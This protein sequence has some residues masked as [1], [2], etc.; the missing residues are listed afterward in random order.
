MN[1][2]PLLDAGDMAELRRLAR[3]AESRLAG[4][5]L[6]GLPGG[7]SRQAGP[8]ER[9]RD[10][11]DYQREDDCRHIDWRASARCGRLQVRVYDRDA[12]DRWY[13]GLDCSASM[14]V[15]ALLWQRAQRITAALAYLLLH[16]GNRVGLLAFT[17]ELIAV[18]PAGAGRGQC[19]RVWASLAR[20]APRRRGGGTDPACCLARLGRADGLILVSDLLDDQ[21][22]QP[23]LGRLRAAC[24]DLH[25][26]QLPN[27]PPAPPSGRR[28]VRD[29]E[30][31][32]GLHLMV[33]GDTLAGVEAR[34]DALDRALDTWC[35]R[36]GVAR[37]RAGNGPDWR[38]PV[39]DYLGLAGAVIDAAR[40][41]RPAARWAHV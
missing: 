37:V 38:Q 33:D 39:L 23:A 18:T 24:A 7:R 13:L 40:S 5:R 30:S 2:V 17:D 4:R 19:T 28:F 1:P 27:R 16:A 12:A 26:I 14:A 32:A 34:L 35:G 22:M 25:L 3:L 10:L 21:A 29:V 31:G 36:T 9:F 41:G 8:G 15:D 20:L 11:R 6:A